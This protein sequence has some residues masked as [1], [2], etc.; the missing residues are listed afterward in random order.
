M[1]A[2]VGSFF[3]V[4]GFLLKIFYTKIKSI[5]VKNYKT[6]QLKHRFDREAVAFIKTPG[7]ATIQ[8][9]SC[10]KVARGN[11]WTSAGYYSLQLIPVTD[12]ARERMQVLFGSDESGHR[13]TTEKSVLFNDADEDEY[14]E[15]MLTASSDRE[16]NFCFENVPAGTYYICNFIRQA[17]SDNVGNRLLGADLMLKVTVQDGET[18]EVQLVY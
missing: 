17:V 1:R 2:F 13:S 6:H 12:H 8:G 5:F 18:L 4:L 15:Y 14:R 7:T 10:I 11:P 9:Q 3:E 16:G